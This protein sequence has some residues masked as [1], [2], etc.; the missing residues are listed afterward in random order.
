MRLPF[1][2]EATHAL[3]VSQPTL[4]R[5][6]TGRTHRPALVANYRAFV[7]VHLAEMTGGD[8]AVKPREPGASNRRAA[9]SPTGFPR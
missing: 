2:P 1:I 6:C 4:W 3:G 9:S 5:A 8:E 7:Q